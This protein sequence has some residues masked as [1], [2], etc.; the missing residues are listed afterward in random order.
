MT[1]KQYIATQGPLPGTVDDFWR[2]IWEQRC[3][4]IVMLTHLVEGGKVC[5]SLQLRVCMHVCVC[6]CV[7]VCVGVWVCGWV[8]VRAYMC[9]CIMRILS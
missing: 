8:S 1:T 4:A 7:C 9:V 5:D 2:L 3:S 6:V